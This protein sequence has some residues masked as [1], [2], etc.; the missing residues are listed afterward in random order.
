MSEDFDLTVYIKGDRKPVS[1]Y[2]AQLILEY[3][4][5]PPPTEPAEVD[6]AMDAIDVPRFVS[7]QDPALRVFTV[8]AEACNLLSNTDTAAG[9][10]TLVG[11]ALDAGVPDVSY[12]QPFSAVAPGDCA[13]G[14]WSWTAPDT[15]TSVRWTATVSVSGDLTDPV[16]ENDTLKKRTTVYPLY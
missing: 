15:G 7:S 3:E 8:S 4:G 11:D 9:T 6:M 10:I 16:P 12:V 14:S 5:E 2:N 13:L 1:L